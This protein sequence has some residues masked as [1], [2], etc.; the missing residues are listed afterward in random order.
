MQIEHNKIKNSNWR[1][2]ISW[3][4]SSVAED[5]NSGQQRT[6]PA[7]GLQPGTGLRVPRAE[8]SATLPQSSLFV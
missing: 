6:N 3:L 7:S 2:A 1:E 8:H 4:F 5:L